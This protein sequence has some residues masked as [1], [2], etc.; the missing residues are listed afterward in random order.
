MQSIEIA[1]E[2]D[3][4]ADE[5]IALDNLGHVAVVWGDLTAAESYYHRSLAICRETNLRNE[6]G[7]ALTGL[8]DVLTQQGR[9]NEADAIL[10]EA[11]ILRR[12]L[13][14]EAVLM[15][16]LAGLARVHLVQGERGKALGDV[17]EILTYLD[18]GGGFDGA[19]YGLRSHLTCYHVLL[20]ND[21]PRVCHTAGCS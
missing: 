19:E 1:R 14:N 3:V 15:E 11:V 18:N 6:E 12:T 4:L 5:T 8:G 10:N 9:L 20:A 13:G 21:D 7:I 16:S 2:I 17:E